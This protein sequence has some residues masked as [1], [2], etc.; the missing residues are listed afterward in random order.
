MVT[1]NA[2]AIKWRFIAASFL[3]LSSDDFGDRACSSHRTRAELADRRSHQLLRRQGNARDR[4]A[5]SMDMLAG[6]VPAAGLTRQEHRNV[7]DRV[8]L[9][10][11]RVAEGHDQ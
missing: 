3:M 7:F 5:H 4:F 11:S 2:I 10:V 8:N 1:V 9:G 6:L